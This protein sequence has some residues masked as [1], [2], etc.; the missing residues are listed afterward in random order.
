[1]EAGTAVMLG[2]CVPFVLTGIRDLALCTL[3]RVEGVNVCMSIE[4]M[5]VRELSDAAS[6]LGQHQNPTLWMLG[7][8]HSHLSDS[9]I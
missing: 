5:D 7:N 3:F 1:M 2:L 6:V 9:L 4:S 8:K